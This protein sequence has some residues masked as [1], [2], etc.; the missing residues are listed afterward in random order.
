[1]SP[2]RQKKKVWAYETENGRGWGSE[3]PSRVWS[4]SPAE[5]DHVPQA[6]CYQHLFGGKGQGFFSSQQN[7]GD[8]LARWAA[9]IEPAFSGL[10]M[11]RSYL[12]YLNLTLADPE[13]RRRK[14]EEMTWGYK[15]EN[16]LQE[17]NLQMFQIK[18]HLHF[19]FFCIFLADVWIWKEKNRFYTGENNLPPSMK[20]IIIVSPSCALVHTGFH[21]DCCTRLNFLPQPHLPPLLCVWPLALPQHW[22]PLLLAEKA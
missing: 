14:A 16:A 5:T 17:L 3:R 7:E 21:S 13:N 2:K 8:S 1:M 22:Y 12:R 18:S 10:G 20:L 19:W 9:V 15:R 6:L 4:G 11:P